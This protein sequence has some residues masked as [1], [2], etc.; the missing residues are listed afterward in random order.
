VPWYI[1]ADLVQ[2]RK[3]VLPSV[4]GWRCCQGLD[5]H[6]LKVV[7]TFTVTLVDFDATVP[8]LL[9]PVVLDEGVLEC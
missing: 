1:D 2:S 3:S 4:K 5:T 6:K 8:A 9:L 7:W